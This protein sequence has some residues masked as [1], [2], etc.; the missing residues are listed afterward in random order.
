MQGFRR[1]E[2]NIFS[3]WW[4]IVITEKNMYL[5][6]ENEKVKTKRLDGNAVAEQHL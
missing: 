6:C 5:S 4:D 3:A 1:Q 2:V